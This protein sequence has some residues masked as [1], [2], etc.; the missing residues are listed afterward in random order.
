MRPRV[1][2]CRRP[3]RLRR[4]T[5]APRQHLARPPASPGRLVPRTPESRE[6]WMECDNSAY[7]ET[8]AVNKGQ[9]IRLLRQWQPMFEA[10]GWL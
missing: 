10:I 1:R 2:L 6:L 8:K 7:L 5:L 9:P 4:R 3:G